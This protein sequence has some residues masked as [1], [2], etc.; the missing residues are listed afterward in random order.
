MSDFIIYENEKTGIRISYATYGYHDKTFGYHDKTSKVSK[1]TYLPNGRILEVES[2]ASCPVLE[3]KGY[4]FK[5]PCFRFYDFY[6]EDQLNFR[7]GYKIVEGEENVEY[8]QYE[9]SGFSRK[10]LEYELKHTSVSTKEY[11]RQFSE[12]ATN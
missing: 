12:N 2:L 1:L 10:D 11:V 6:E 3:R 8:F 4:P 5:H 7:N 9:L